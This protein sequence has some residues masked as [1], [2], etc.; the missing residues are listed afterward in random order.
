MTHFGD[1][2]RKPVADVNFDMT[3]Q[4]SPYALRNLL[5]TSDSRFNLFT[6]FSWQQCIQWPANVS[7]YFLSNFS[8][9]VCHYFRSVYYCFGVSHSGIVFIKTSLSIF[10]PRSLQRRFVLWL[11][12]SAHCRGWMNNNIIINKSRAIPWDKLNSTILF[13]KRLPQKWITD[14]QK[15]IEYSKI[16]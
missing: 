2:I 13:V 16:A 9:I 14:R 12:K 15:K 5:R 8:S 6:N 7:A 1:W 4:S 10:W 3:A 11:S